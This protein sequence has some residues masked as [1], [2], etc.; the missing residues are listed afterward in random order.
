MSRVAGSRISPLERSTA[1]KPRLS[2]SNCGSEV[3]A[4]SIFYKRIAG[5]PDRAPI[6]PQPLRRQLHAEF[7]RFE[8][9]QLD[10]HLVSTFG[11]FEWFERLAVLNGFL[12]LE[13]LL[14]R[15]RNRHF[16]WFR[17]PLAEALCLRGLQWLVAGDFRAGR[18]A[19]RFSILDR[20][21]GDWRY[22]R[23][24]MAKLIAASPSRR[25]A[26][27]PEACAHALS[28]GW[29]AS[30][31]SGA[32]FSR[33]ETLPGLTASAV[34]IGTK[35]RRSMDDPSRFPS[36]EE[37]VAFARLGSRSDPTDMAAGSS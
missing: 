32:Q 36:P 28:R 31:S 17:N 12:R 1:D 21:M 33:T 20:I 37:Q 6:L 11:L 9:S 25:C 18:S 8:H 5:L 15:I 24:V 30:S 4:T 23:E 19:G 13:A 29:R 14:D 16:A 10:P 22:Y 7:R 3:Y 35:S 34:A 26:A 2:C 27:H